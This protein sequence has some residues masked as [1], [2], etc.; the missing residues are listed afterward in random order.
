[1]FERE[2]AF[3]ESK[4][5]EFHEKYLDKWLVITGTSLLGVYDT[6]ADAAKAALEQLE[7]GDFILHRP[8]DDGKILEIGPFINIHDPSE[9]NTQKPKTISAF[10]DGDLIR[11]PYV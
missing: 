10:C 3:Y 9:D 5:A 7:P 2:N 8:A 1:M 4:Q 11:F 6:I